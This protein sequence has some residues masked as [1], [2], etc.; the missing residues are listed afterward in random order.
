MCAIV[1]MQ[2]QNLTAK[3]TRT[4]SLP[5]HIDPSRSHS[6]RGT[7]VILHSNREIVL[8]F[9]QAIYKLTFTC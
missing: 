7:N 6:I 4:Q 1:L 9:Q 5:P 2:S 3:R 8:T